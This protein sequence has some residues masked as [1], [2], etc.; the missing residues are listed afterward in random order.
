VLL[1]TASDDGT[2]RV[3]RVS[4]GATLSV[5]R[6]H[7][8]ALVSVAI[9]PDG[10]TVA[11]GA[12]DGEILLWTVDGTLV[13][14][15]A[16]H[17]DEV[18]GLGF[19]AGGTRIFS[20]SK[21]GSL[22]VWSASDLAPLGAPIASGSPLS[23]VAVSP[24]GAHVAIGGFVYAF[25]LYDAA[26]AAL[27][28][29]ITTPWNIRSLDYAP[30]G[31]RVYATLANNDVESYQ[32]DG[33]ASHLMLAPIGTEALVAASPLGDDVF[34][35]S[36]WA[37]WLTDPTGASRRDPI[38]EGPFTRSLAFSSDGKRLAIGGDFG[39]VVRDTST[40][41]ILAAP[42]IGQFA[43]AYNGLAFSPDG[44]KLASADDLGNVNLWSGASF[45]TKTEVTKA[46]IDAQSV[47]F[48][49]DGT[50]LAMAGREGLD[51]LWKLSPLGFVRSFGYSDSGHSVA[52]SPD[53]ALAALGTENRK[54]GIFSSSDWSPL[55]QID[56]A[57]SVIVEDLA[58]SLD[59]K[60]LATTGDERVTVWETGSNAE[61]R[62]V[63][64]LTAYF[65]KTVAISPDGG[66]L[67]AG[68]SDGEVRSWSLPDLTPQPVLPG[69]G[70]G[71]VKARFSPA[72]D[73][74][75][76]YDDGTTW[77]WCRR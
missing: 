28:K 33:S 22:R 4:D 56:S 15:K 27:E 19:A 73:L 31:D 49:P 35:A 18:R 57:H 20:A 7:D 67:V 50:W 13:T 76:G 63:L 60:L 39:F 58:F 9:A 5:L 68:G 53:G 51:D 25:S 77:L 40:Q 8:H 12:I 48:S 62:D 10:S 71:I 29:T 55:R 23:I 6:A 41:A 59:G 44:M 24:D 38:Q 32:T 45:K 70:S 34:V 26:S 43:R 52:F 54:L 36:G 37:L 17:K 16:V 2:V 11:A 74:A 61:R 46:T 21:D 42:D 66:R 75:V 65:G 14:S 30:S 69:H 47:A 3:F 64:N 72:G 1:A